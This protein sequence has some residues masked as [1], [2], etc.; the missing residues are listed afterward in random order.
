MRR[1]H[2]AGDFPHVLDAVLL[3]EL[4]D[5]GNHLQR[6]LR[7][8]EIRRAHRHRRRAGHHEFNRIRRVLDAA[9][10]D[11]G[12]FHR[13]RRFPDQFDGNR[14]DARAGQAA[15]DVC[16]LR[17]AR[18][19]VN[20]HGRVTV[21]DGQRVAAG[22]FRRLGVR[23]DAHHI[24]AHLGDQW[25]LRRLAARGYNLCEQFHVRAELRAA[26][27]DVGAGDIEFQRADAAQRVESPRHLGV[28]V[29]RRA[30]DIDDGR[31]LSIF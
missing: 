28:F 13:L 15:G 14:L 6:R 27:L 29:N 4:A 20:R 21:R 11:D 5:A 3:H 18:L 24:R 16:Q 31:E 9:H 2:A 26:F 7:F 10:A 17:L 25:Q 30:P 23:R 19:D 8:V 22:V 12:N 1:L